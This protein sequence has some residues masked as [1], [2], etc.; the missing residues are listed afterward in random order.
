[1]LVKRECKKVEGEGGVAKRGEPIRWGC[2]RERNGVLQAE[3]RFFRKP[4]LCASSGQR[5]SKVLLKIL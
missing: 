4:S 5:V 1:M 3:A 2:K